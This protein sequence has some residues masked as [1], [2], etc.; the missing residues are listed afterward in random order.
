MDKV[1]R[2]GMGWI[3]FTGEIQDGN[4]LEEKGGMDLVQRRKVVWIGFR[5][6][7]WDGLNLNKVA[8]HS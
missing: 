4:G 6:E 5:G 3:G 2:I 8:I 7:G 1:Q